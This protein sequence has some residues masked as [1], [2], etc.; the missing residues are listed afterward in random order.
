MST[1]HEQIR[2]ADEVIVRNIAVLADQRDL[3]SQNVLAQ[4][5]NLVEGLIV[6]AHGRDGAATFRQSDVGDALDFVRADAR[7]NVLS[8][9]HHRLQG[10]TSHYTLAGDPSERLML[11]YFE[12]LVRIR[13]LAAARLSVT[14]LRN[15]D[16]FPL[17][18]DESL[19]EY[20]EHI[21]SRI[22]QP[23]DGQ[24]GTTDVYYVH[25]S[26]P[27]FVG[28]RIF[29]EVTFSV[30]H[31]RT[32]KFD[33]HI[34]F[35]DIDIS[36]KYAARL[37]VVPDTIDVIGQRMPIAL[38]RGWSIAIRGC[39]FD[40]LRRLLFGPHNE[41]VRPT[42]REYQNAMRY[43][44]DTR[45]NLL[46]LIDMSDAKYEQ[47]RTWILHDVERSALIMPLLD[48][49][50][51]IIRRPATGG[52]NL[53]RFLLLRMYNNLIRDQLSRD[54][55][56]PLSGMWATHSSRPFDT[57]PFCTSPYKHKAGF[58]DLA[59]A[60]DSSTRRHEILAKRIQTNVEV[61]GRIYTRDSDLDGFGGLD[62]LVARHNALLP[63]NN[64][65]HAPRALVHANGHVFIKG[66]EDDTVE[67]VG[68]LQDIAADGLDGYTEDVDAWLIENPEE[69]DDPLKA[70][71][72][73][74]L[75]AHSRV[76][77]VYGAAGTGKSRMVDH[78]ATHFESSRKLFLAHTN[79]AVD[80]LRNAVHDDVSNSE[81][82]TIHGHVRNRT[83]GGHYDL[84]VIDECS[85][86]SNASLLDVLR[87]TSFDLLVL[88]GDVYQIEAIEF[89]NWFA[90]I[91]SYLPATSVFELTTPWRTKDPA[92]LTLWDRVRNL[93]DRIEESLSTSRYS[94]VLGEALF[95]TRGADEIVLCINYDGVYGI[96]NVNR[97]LQASNPSPPV[98]RRGA[99]FKVNDPVLF[100][101]TDRFR[102]VIYN[103][104]KG[105]LVGITT[106]PGK[107]TFDV[108]LAR[109]V[110]PMDVWGTDLT[111]IE[112]STVR[113]DVMDMV[114]PD[115][116]DDTAVTV[117]PFQIAYAVSFHKAQGL[118][119]DSV[120]V[121]ITDVNESRVSH[122]MFYTAIT[123]ARR[124][125][126]VYWTAQTQARILDR[127]QP[128]DST[129]DEAILRERC[130]LIPVARR[131]RMPRPRRAP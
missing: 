53:L 111:L 128:R 42:Q 64:P 48:E 5:R 83:N 118:E 72:L 115:D 14:I 31:N 10:S 81:F 60:L 91:R 78:I 65:R 95:Q 121:V 90:S 43:L 11:K 19:R 21:A 98:V 104:L 52:Q 120:K 37:E 88:V 89:G 15:L 63:P 80:N 84:V 54:R 9:F 69:V 29:Y 46:D 32:S 13:D 58:G 62:A 35:T 110:D 99:T 131:P 107:I 75:F 114:D 28:G 67:V 130:G 7:L 86:V 47:I 108:E 105:T 122:A 73:R 127:F 40:N 6:L 12:Y 38:I 4:L 23:L 55:C 103:N 113:F 34:G 96:N 82:S 22:L 45:S 77:L 56:W 17:Q 124:N 79:P 61:D 117:I 119:F 25:S 8:R 94:A 59:E 16:E 1:I 129:T 123:R 26:R 68:K 125:L 51:R 97:F 116:D 74:S 66:Y 3:L 27:F 100:N 87:V 41:R 92:L 50:R 18:I 85:T 112:G 39:E 49:A 93:D 30:A 44:T 126:E 109:E 57:M 76:A 33:R 24:A 106:S 101:D 102:G 36:D 20:Y 71:A 70:E 2:D